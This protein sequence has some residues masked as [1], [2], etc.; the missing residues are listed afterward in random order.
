MYTSQQQAFLEYVT[1]K[2]KNLFVE[3]PAPGHDFQHASN[4]GT[5]AKDVA[6]KENAHS[7][8]LSELAGILHDIGRAPEHHNP[9]NKLRH[10]D[11]SYQMLRQWFREDSQFDF[12]TR[13]EKLELL[14]SVKYHWNDAADDYDT[15]WILRDADKLDGLGCRGLERFQQYRAGDPAGIGLDCRLTYQFW[16]WIHTATARQIATQKKLIE[17]MDKIII[18]DLKKKIEP[19]EL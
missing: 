4:V 12:L 11:L 18:E 3:F 2:V 9:E 1:E 8:F 17:E 15:A 7:I 19:V 13:E 16:Y 14:Y 6:T 5:Y 10:H